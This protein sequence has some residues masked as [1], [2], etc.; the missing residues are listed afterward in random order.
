MSSCAVVHSNSSVGLLE[1]TMLHTNQVGPEL[2]PSNYSCASLVVPSECM[3]S[4][5]CCSYEKFL[6]TSDLQIIIH[7]MMLSSW[8]CA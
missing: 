4:V 3:L 6:A 7:D 5:S 2:F 1:I 8:S